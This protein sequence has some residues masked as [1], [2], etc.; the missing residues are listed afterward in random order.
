MYSA[1]YHYYQVR[2]GPVYS[3]SLPAAVVA[4]AVRRIAGIQETGPLEFGNAEDAPWLSLALVHAGPDGSYASEPRATEINAVV[5]VGS[6]TRPAEACERVLLAL[7]RDL[8]WQL[9]LEGDED[10]TLWQPGID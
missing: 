7:A 4:G 5:A 8:G 9:L 10:I 3:P 6:R 1:F 2:S